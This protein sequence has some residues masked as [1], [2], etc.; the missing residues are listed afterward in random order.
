MSFPEVYTNC[1]TALKKKKKETGINDGT[2]HAATFGRTPWGMNC[3][4]IHFIPFLREMPAMHSSK[5]S[6][7]LIVG[8]QEQLMCT[9]QKM[10]LWCSQH[11][12]QP[13]PC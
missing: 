5:F 8:L 4:M 11:H 3:E 6:H 7:R 10:A 2:A 13:L 9:Q 1:R 12:Q